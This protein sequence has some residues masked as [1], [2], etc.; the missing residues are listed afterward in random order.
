MAKKTDIDADL[1]RTLAGLLDETGLSEIEYGKDGLNIRVA[2]NFTIA[3]PAAPLAAA[4]AAAQVAPSE[5]AADSNDDL[6]SHPGAVTSPMVGVAYTSSDPDSPPFVTVGDQVSTGQTLLLVEAM[7]V[8]NP[9][10][11]PKSGKITR[12]LFESGD[13]VEF[14]APLMI[15]E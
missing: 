9:I 8:F 14:G 7:K 5:P 6:S 11:A 1:V 13:P 2:K 10:T 15:I 12:I 4:P 3:A